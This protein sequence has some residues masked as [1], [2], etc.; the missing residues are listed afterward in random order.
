MYDILT[1]NLNHLLGAGQRVVRST[2]LVKRGM[3]Y[4]I[5]AKALGSSDFQIMFRHLVPNAIVPRL[6]QVTLILAFALLAESGLSF[7]GVGGS[8]E[9]PDWGGK[10]SEVRLVIS[11]APCLVLLP[12]LLIT[13]TVFS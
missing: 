6:V 13:L 8:T 7:L 4:V 12:G 10:F 2:M 11:K 1:I 9:L 5:A 3:D